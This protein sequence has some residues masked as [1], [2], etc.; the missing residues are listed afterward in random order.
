MAP[1][2]RGTHDRGVSWYKV[3]FDMF[4]CFLVTFIRTDGFGSLTENDVTGGTDLVGYFLEFIYGI[5]RLI[6]KEI[7]KIHFLA[8]P[9]PEKG[10]FFFW[11]A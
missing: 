8:T 7:T 9:T 6:L 1:G 10:N 3:P 11:G 2:Y 5:K 4:L